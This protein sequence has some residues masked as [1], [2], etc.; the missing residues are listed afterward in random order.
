[1]PDQDPE[2]GQYRRRV[3]EGGAVDRQLLG[4]HGLAVAEQLEQTQSRPG[5]EHGPRAGMTTQGIEAKGLVP[6]NS[7]GHYVPL[8]DRKGLPVLEAEY[9]FTLKAISQDKPAAAKPVI[10]F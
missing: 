6:W 9:G 3:S 8:G 7:T 2:V 10:D 1:M 5:E 4:Q